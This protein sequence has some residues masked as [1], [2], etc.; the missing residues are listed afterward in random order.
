[1]ASPSTQACEVDFTDVD[2]IE[3]YIKTKQEEYQSF[4]WKDG[5]LWEQF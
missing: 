5:D 2:S 1:M 4:D 3:K